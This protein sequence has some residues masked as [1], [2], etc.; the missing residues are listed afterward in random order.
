VGHLGNDK[1]PY[2]RHWKSCLVSPL[3]ED[4][5]RRAHLWSRKTCPLADTESAGAWI[6][7][8]PALRSVSN[9]TVLFI[10]HPLYGNLSR[11]RQS[12]HSLEFG[13]FKHFSIMFSRLIHVVACYQCFIPCCSWIIFNYMGIPHFKTH[14]HEYFFTYMKK[15]GERINNAAMNSC[16]K[17]CSSNITPC[18]SVSWRNLKSIVNW[19]PL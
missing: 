11:K 14:S 4:T 19:G 12:M 5:E 13:F 9:K 8:L 1:Y 17:K 15:K 18:T 10:S 3:C 6:L 16:V 2:K 7:D